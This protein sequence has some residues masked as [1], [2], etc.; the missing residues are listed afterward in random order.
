MRRALVLLLATAAIAQTP[1]TG[2]LTLSGPAVAENGAAVTLTVTLSNG[3]GPAGLQWDMSGL[4]AGAAV[5]SSVAGKTAT[6]N[7]TRCLLV[8]TN[9]TAI[10]DGP[11]ATIKYTQST[12]AVTANLAATLGATP[13]GAAA[14]VTPPAMA[15]TIGVQSNCDVNAD[16]KVDATDVGIV[17]QSALAATTGTP[18]VLDVLREIIAANGGACLR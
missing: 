6:C 15:L 2:T 7:A 13:A 16:G 4:P 12:A 10:P 17:L 5:A 8:G 18:T 3:G 11:I 14:T 9:A 1:L